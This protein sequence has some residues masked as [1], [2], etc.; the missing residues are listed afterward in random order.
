MGQRMRKDRLAMALVAVLRM[1]HHVFDHAIGPAAAREVRDHGEHA[2]RHQSALEVAAE[3]LVAR[4]GE[5]LL[6]DGLHHRGLGQRI[7]RPVQ[8][9]VEREQCVQFVGL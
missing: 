8:V 3:D 9:G 7:V 5:K 4:V 1:R 6:P 2:A